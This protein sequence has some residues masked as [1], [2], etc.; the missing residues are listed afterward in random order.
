MDTLLVLIQIDF[1]FDDA[2]LI[3]KRTLTAVI[4]RR[5]LDGGESII[6]EKVNLPS[7]SYICKESLKLYSC[8][9][10]CC[11]YGVLLCSQL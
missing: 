9:E 7:H 10:I 6:E 2:D 1:A 8:Y 5:K 4:G 11:G 3:D